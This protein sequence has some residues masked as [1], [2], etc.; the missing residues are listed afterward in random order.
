MNPSR[1]VWLVPSAIII[2]GLILAVAV[3]MIRTSTQQVPETAMPEMIEPVSV[4]DHIIGNPQASVIIVEYSDIDSDDGKN[5]H[6]ALE[7]LMTEYAAGG[8]VAW[9]YRHLPLT[10]IH[11]YSQRHAEASECASSL[12]NTDA[13][14]RFI[15]QAHTIAPGGAEL[16]PENYAFIAQTLGIESA[17]FDE[18]INSGRF[19]AKVR[20]QAHDALG[21]G[22]KGAPFS[23]V[24]IE[25]SEPVVINGTLP[26]L[27][28]KE[29]VERSLEKVR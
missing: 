16:Y 29:L 12:G 9:V 18:C 19:A 17:V 28:L 22:A 13:F 5:F 1:S 25:G 24:L 8:K 21:A 3:F 4:S 6:Q 14:W 27:A 7:Q 11:A 2:A 23:V 26:Y 20:A 10:T 15:G